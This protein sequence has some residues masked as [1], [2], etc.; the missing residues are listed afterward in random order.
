MNT[1]TKTKQQTK[2]DELTILIDDYTNIYLPDYLDALELEAF[3]LVNADDLFSEL[4]DKGAFDVDIFYYNK[5]M[6]YLSDNDPSLAESISIAV[7]MGV[8]LEHISSEDLASL[9]ASQK[10]RQDFWDIIDEIDEI[11]SR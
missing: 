1:Q 3:N 2:F 4:D 7:E 9:H 11:L 5:A 10:A 6:E 8:E